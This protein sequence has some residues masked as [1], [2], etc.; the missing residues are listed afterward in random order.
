MAEITAVVGKPKSVVTLGDKQANYSW[1][2]P[3]YQ[4]ILAFKDDIC[5]GGVWE[6]L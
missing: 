4:I 6:M 3:Q 1:D 5:Q 2:V